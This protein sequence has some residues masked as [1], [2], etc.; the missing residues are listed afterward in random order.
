M[1]FARRP[2]TDTEAARP[3]PWC[4]VE[5]GQRCVNPDG[6]LFQPGSHSSRRTGV[7]IGTPSRRMGIGKNQVT[8]GG[9]YEFGLWA[10]T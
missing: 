10:P 9:H 2:L 3:C 7:L 6:S 8:A 4:A 1:P 5:P